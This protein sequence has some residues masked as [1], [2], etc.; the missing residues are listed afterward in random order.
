MRVHA[1]EFIEHHY[2]K[3]IKVSDIAD[4]IGINRSYLTACFQK[5]IG[6]SPQQYL[7]Q[8]R[9]E[10]ACDLLKTTDLSI[11]AVASE[12]GY[13]DPLAFSRSF[14]QMHDSSPKDFRRKNGQTIETDIILEH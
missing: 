3:E 13:A 4:Y 9:M 6:V 10:K 1:L 2:Q 14:R 11:N 5:S 7:I 8:Y 12:V